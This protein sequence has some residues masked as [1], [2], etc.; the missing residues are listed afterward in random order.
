MSYPFASVPRVFWEDS[1]GDRIE[2]SHRT[3]LSTDPPLGRWLYVEGPKAA[4][5]QI[6]MASGGWKEV[7]V[8]EQFKSEYCYCFEYESGIP[9]AV[10]HLV[11]LLT[12]D[13][14][15][16]RTRP[17]VDAAVALDWYKTPEDGVHPM[18]WKNT[19]DGSLLNRA[20]YHNSPQAKAELLARYLKVVAQHPIFR[21]VPTLATVPGS[22]GDG[23]SF[24]ERLAGAVAK[25]C[26]KALVRTLST[27]PHAPSKEGA[28]HS[29]GDFVMP[30]TLVGDVLVIDDVYRS[31]ASMAVTAHAA[32]LAG[33]SRVFGLVAARTL[34]N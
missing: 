3:R 11:D 32:K 34:R 9:L 33:A 22:A 13:V 25:E 4:A 26:G 14:L 28:T 19:P 21:T 6:R 8:P 5:A 18:H 10:I 12:S 29:Y 27:G 17:E 15:T 23:N 30:E 20:K 1:R 24:G 31:G 7:P 16:V 2:R